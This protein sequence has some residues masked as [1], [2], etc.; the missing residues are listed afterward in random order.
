M[1]SQHNLPSEPKSLGVPRAAWR[2]MGVMP[3]GSQLATSLQLLFLSNENILGKC[4]C[5]S[6]SCTGPR[7]SVQVV[8]YECPQPLLLIT[9]LLPKNNQKKNRSRVLFCYSWLV[10][11]VGQPALNTSVSSE[12]CIKLLNECTLTCWF[13]LVWFF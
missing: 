1:P 9:A 2:V 12:K 13:L 3:P 7:I 11:T 8:Q 4:F 10:C 6:S 5:F